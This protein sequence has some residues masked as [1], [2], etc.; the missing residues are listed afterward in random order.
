MVARGYEYDESGKLPAIAD[1]RNGR[2]TYSYDNIGRI[3]SAVQLNLAERFAFD[4]AH[5]LLDETVTSAARVEGNRVRV[6]QDKRYD[7][8]AHGNLTL[9]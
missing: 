9:S 1:K 5:N 4:P 3:M 8:D 7:H 2:K 6:F